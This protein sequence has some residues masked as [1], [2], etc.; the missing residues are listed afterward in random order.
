MGCHL[1]PVSRDRVALFLIR[2]DPATIAKI[3]ADAIEFESRV[4][5]F[6]REGVVDWYP[7]FSA[8]DAATMYERS[9][10]EQVI[11]FD[12]DVSDKV[13]ELIDAQRAKKAVTELI[14]K[15]QGEIMDV[16]GTMKRGRLR[17]WPRCCNGEVGHDRRA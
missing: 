8:N 15:L 7:A 14:A 11:D 2:P 17:G 4:E 16:M 1:C 6:R 13:L 9:E 10:P 5:T 12:E 3:E